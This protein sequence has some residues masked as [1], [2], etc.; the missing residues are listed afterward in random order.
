M[1]DD[2]RY[3]KKPVN[4]VGAVQ[5]RIKQASIELKDLA[6][7]L[8][9]GMSC[10]ASVLEKGRSAEGW[11]NQQVFMID[12]DHNITIKEVM[13]ECNRINILP[14]F[15]YTS[16][17]HTEAEHRFRLVFI[18]DEII[19]DGEKRDRL[20]VTLMHLFGESDPKCLNRDRLFFGGKDKVPFYENYESRINA[21][22]IINKFFKD[23]YQ[24]K[25]DNL[26]TS[27]KKKVKEKPTKSKD[28]IPV[29]DEFIENIQ[30]IKE[31]NVLKMQR[32]LNDLQKGVRDKKE[33][34]YQV[35]FSMKVVRSKGELYRF[36]DSID[37][38]TFLGISEGEFINCI[39]PGHVD[40]TP[41]AHI[42]T[43]KNGT[44][45]YKCFG[46][47]KALGI[48]SLVQILGKTT[49]RK[50]IDFI[51]KVYNVRFLESEWIREQREI[52]GDNM[53]YLDSET[54]E[55]E[56]PHITRLIK[57]RK[58]H[59]RALS[60]YFEDF[61]NEELKLDD[62]PLFFAGYPKLLS[63]CGINKNKPITLSQ[64]LSL[65]NLLNMIEKVEPNRIPS[66]QLKKAKHISAMY[67]FKKLT[68]FYQFPE[69]GYIQLED[70][71]QIAKTLIENHISI[72]GLSR[73]YLLRTF[74]TELADKIFPQ[75]IY[76]NH[77]GSGTTP[78]SDTMT[79]EISKEML[80]VIAS[81][82]YILEK[83]FNINNKVHTQWKKSIKEILDT[84]S[85]VRVRATKDNKLKYNIPEDIPYQSFV[86]CPDR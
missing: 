32:I 39:L 84:Y 45:I 43:T 6:F 78:K 28:K 55:I 1:L 41:S 36:I 80:K 57:K 82:G 51:T 16:F 5:N 21:D 54:F 14:C 31:L 2:K 66:D 85:L 71:E 63:V 52:M 8:C 67:G 11:L 42:F 69:Y 40:S 58:V 60:T 27:K 12:Y 75:Y 17:S 13:Q 83:Q 64:S 72:K 29:Q 86:I 7:G 34:C 38:C 4:D 10:R 37:L 18:T 19:T 24:I 73:E 22:D 20:Q 56:F 77:R 76:E 74:G 33:S 50:A 26:S 61:I 3:E 47:D 48:I 44:K 81:Q 25:I 68:N 46:C 35:P 53:Y 65:F 49:R 30:A 70:S 23:E 62:K 79:L 9:N 59:L 15:G